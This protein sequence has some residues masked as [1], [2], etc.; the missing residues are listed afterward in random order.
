MAEIR[1][2]VPAFEGLVLHEDRRWYY[3]FW[4]PKG[5]MAHSLSDDRIGVLCSPTEED[6]DTFFSVEVIPLQAAVQPSDLPVLCEGVQE[7]LSQLPGLVVESAEETAAGGRV[8]IERTYTFEDQ[9]TTRK[10]RV[11]LV[12][13]D[14]RLYSLMAQGATVAEY[15]YWLPMLNYCHLNFTL[16]LFNPAQFDLSGAA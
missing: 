2:G 10:R 12:Y 7:G 13:K 15:E 5:W 9:A 8:T 14:D 11:R 1:E 16:G 3:T 6:L 4:Y